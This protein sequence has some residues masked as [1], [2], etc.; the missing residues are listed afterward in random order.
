[1]NRPQLVLDIG[2][3]LATNLSPLFW[4]LLAADV[5]FAEDV[6][7]GDYKKLVSERLWTGVITEEQ[8]WD[9][10]QSYAHQLNKEQARGYIDR[11][12]QPLPALAKV[13][14]WSEVAE[15]HL[16]S[17]H[18]SAWVDPIVQPI[19]PYLKSMTISNEVALKKP[20]PDIFAKVIEK[21]PAGSPVLF[22]D[23]H[24]KNTKQA[25]SLGWRTLLADEEG[26]WIKK[27]I[28]LLK[29]IGE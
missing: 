15:I 18:L 5:G 17:N 13:A 4:Q 8:F 26:L 7:Y 6:I 3:V 16:L 19:R 20:H 25:A 11:S 27:V 14:E 23:D 1:M 21:L 22:V 2:G 12:L 9:W 29:Q 10:V 24:P 28:P